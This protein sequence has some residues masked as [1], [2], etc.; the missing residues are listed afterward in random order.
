MPDAL[1]SVS[2]EQ[3]RK[4]LKGA[5]AVSGV[6]T[7]GYSGAAL[8]SF[9]CVAQGF[10][11]GGFPAGTSQFAIGASPPSTPTHQ[12]WAWKGVQVWEYKDG[13]TKY[14]GFSIPANSNV[15]N[16]ANPTQ[17]LPGTAGKVNSTQQTNDGYPKQAWVLAYFDQAGNLNGVY[18]SPQNVAAATSAPATQSCL[19]SINPS[20]SLGN[21]TFGG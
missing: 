4:L 15:Y 20:L 9:D 19:A 6:A 17:T 1:Q 7:M 8:A 16:A 12:G 2:V 18:P 3:R 10:A 11:Q 14:E 13:S 5:L 21:F